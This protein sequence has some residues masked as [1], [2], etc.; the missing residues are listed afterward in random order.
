MNINDDNSA[1]SA[2]AEGVAKDESNAVL[3][4]ASFRN[5][6]T[7]STSNSTPA[8]TPSLVEN[9][10]APPAA[11]KIHERNVSWGQSS[12]DSESRKLP[13]QPPER[14]QPPKVSLRDVLQQHPAESE[15][16]TRVLE[17]VETEQDPTPPPPPA[18]P[19]TLSAQSSLR[20]SLVSQ[21]QQQ[22]RSSANLLRHVP[23]G[24]EGAFRATE[25]QPSEKSFD[26]TSSNRSHVS[27]LRGV[28]ER[29]M[30]HK[31]TKTMEQRLDSLTDA[32]EMI[33]GDEAD[34]LMKFLPPDEEPAH[35][36]V[37]TMNK[38][39]D[40]LRQR[41]RKRTED[42]ELQGQTTPTTTAASNWSKVRTLHMTVGLA[43]AIENSDKE[44]HDELDSASDNVSA[45]PRLPTDLET[46]LDDARMPPADLGQQQLR[47]SPQHELSE[48]DFRQPTEA[49]GADPAAYL[50]TT[51][52]KTDRVMEKIPGLREF[53][54]FAKAN[55]S[56]VRAYVL[57]ILWII[58]P[59]VTIAGILFYLAGNPP[60]GRVDLN[61]TAW[62]DELTNLDGNPIDP[63]K[64]SASY[65]LLYICV[66]KLV[67]FSLAQAA[68]LFI[69][70]FMCLGRRWASQYLGPI[71]TL[72]IVQS[73]GWPFL[74]TFWCVFDLGMNSGKH[75]VRPPCWCRFEHPDL[76]CDSTKLFLLHIPKLVCGPLAF[77]ARSDRTFQ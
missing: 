33:H 24:A 62:N 14:K 53:I 30:Q 40:L 64:A 1:K 29:L 76:Q 71:T 17:S 58:L 31:R 65:W 18:R 27:T 7:T 8:E 32:L 39:A 48:S 52:T 70:D 3:A 10:S 73:R 26:G 35:G 43:N 60:T 57:V 68:Q 28:A 66:R 34:E 47:P 11:R 42:V 36:S 13:P 61:A 16:V 22:L 51:N 46:G 2:E 75:K 72:L 25:S 20:R 19:T 4:S 49:L 54:A 12:L 41:Q 67:T 44:H 45:P 37:D 74:L 21:D 6:A 9:P 55:Q 77:L 50:K 63:G 69:I 15:A 56:Q 38:H 59:A 5:S 23:V